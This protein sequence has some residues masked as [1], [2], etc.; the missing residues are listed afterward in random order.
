MPP[1]SGYACASQQDS[2]V[3]DG[4]RATLV[5]PGKR[6]FE[7]GT[8]DVVGREQSGFHIIEGRG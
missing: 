5:L 2:L 1:A 4:R 6:I 3:C 8:C 7:A